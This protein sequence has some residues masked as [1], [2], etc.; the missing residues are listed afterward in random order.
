MLPCR[1]RPQATIAAGL[2]T[3]GGWFGLLLAAGWSASAAVAP[4][5][6]A[7][8]QL[9]A[10]Q[11]VAKNVA[12]RGGLEAW[13]KVQTMIWVGRMESASAPTPG[14]HFVLQ[15]KRPNKTRFEVNALNQHSLRVFDG[16]SG[17]K[18]RSGTGRGA[19]LTPY[20]PQETKFA[21]GE[22]AIDGPLIDYA[23]KGSVVKL[24]GVE[25]IDGRKAYRLVVHLA[26]GDRQDVFVDAQSFLDIRVDRMSYTPAGMPKVVPV[27][28]RNFKGFGGLQIPT[29]IEIGAGSAGAPDK[30]EIDSVTLNPELD[31]QL[32]AKPGSHPRR[33]GP[34]VPLPQAAAEP[35]A[36][37]GPLAEPMPGRESVQQ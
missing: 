36:P 24:E 10:A 35:A 8:P 21:E 27:L 29:T 33:A 4:H 20:N 22:Q 31:D 23:A 11:I 37:G 14:M 12:A 15:Q 30:I 26:S 9:T 19:G 25:E 6:P 7:A 5:S 13:R 32:F 18:L 2:L 34:A 3:R 1:R 17:W 16:V 28:Y